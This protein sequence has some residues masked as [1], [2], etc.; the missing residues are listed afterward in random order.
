MFLFQPIDFQ[1][2][3]QIMIGSTVSRR[4]YIYF[5]KQNHCTL[6]RSPETTEIGGRAKTFSKEHDMFFWILW[7]YDYFSDRRIS[8]KRTLHFFKPY[9]T[10]FYNAKQILRAYKEWFWQQ[11]VYSRIACSGFAS[12]ETSFRPPE[13]CILALWDQRYFLD[14]TIPKTVYLL[15]K[16]KTLDKTA[17]DIS[18]KRNSSWRTWSVTTA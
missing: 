17:G 16:T 5:W 12:A 6:T 18:R 7:S 10:I 9:S 11:R 14:L 4:S 8:L 13:N 2:T 3:K 15:L 1:N